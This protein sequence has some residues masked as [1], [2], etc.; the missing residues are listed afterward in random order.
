MSSLK[1]RESARG[2]HKTN[3]VGGLSGTARIGDGVTFLDI[4]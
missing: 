1:M 2:L 4:T 3:G